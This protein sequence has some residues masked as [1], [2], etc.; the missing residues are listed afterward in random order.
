MRATTSAVPTMT[1]ACGPPSSLSP[2][3]QTTVAPASMLERA[4]GSS[5]RSGRS[6]SW[7][8][9]RSSITGTPCSAA[10]AAS[11]PSDGAPV[12]PTIRKFDWWTR[13][14]APVSGPTTRA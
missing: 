2:E 5:A 13:R 1:P 3:K 10:R 8:E 7:P 9:P 6:M 12:N 11:S 4:V 14:M